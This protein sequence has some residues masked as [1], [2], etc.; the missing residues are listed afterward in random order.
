MIRLW[1]GFFIAPLAFLAEL[2]LA[3]AL[4]PYACQ[5]EHHAPLH[6]LIGLTLAVA[7]WA[8]LHAWREYR[9]AGDVPP[10]DD[11]D[12]G[13]RDRFVAMSGA[14]ISATVSLAILAQWITAWVIPPCVR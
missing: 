11:G 2:A 7:V 10:Y 3:Y 8:T 6:I 13:T 12:K 14:L 1:P 4:V 5:S 9:A